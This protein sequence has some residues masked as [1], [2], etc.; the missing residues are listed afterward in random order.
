MSNANSPAYLE[1][2]AHSVVGLVREHNEDALLSVPELGLWAVA[3]GMGGYQKGELASALVL[4][5]LE[6]ALRAGHSLEQA[7]QQANAWVLE[8]A[9]GH[10]DRVG[11]G[12]TVVAVVFQGY[13]Y[14]LAW[15][16]DSRAYA[17]DA[18]GLRQLSRDH[19]WVQAMLDA[20]QLAPEQARS[21]PR[22]HVITQC[23]GREAGPLDVGVY[24]GEL[25]AGESLLLCSDGLSAEVDDAALAQLCQNRAPLESQVLQ[26]IAAAEAA[27]GHDNISCVLIARPH[28]APTEP[29]QRAWWLRWLPRGRG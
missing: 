21:H 24:R 20:G 10:A 17:C 1:Y 12:S 2:C 8:Q 28:A 13:H 15:V 14:E 9:Q 26:L 29:A 4:Q 27:G 5:S 16:G 19:S 6:S 7:I 23:L 22:R 11:M 3:D 18:N 25:A